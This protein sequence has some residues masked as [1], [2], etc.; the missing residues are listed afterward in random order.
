[1]RITCPAC[2]ILMQVPS[3]VLSAGENRLV[4]EACNGLISI[5]IAR[6]ETQSGP[7]PAGSTV[8]SNS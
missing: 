5:R 1:M 8:I 7:A 6:E 2:G 3:L 4:C